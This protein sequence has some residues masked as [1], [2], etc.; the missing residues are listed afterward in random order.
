MAPALQFSPE[1]L[2]RAQGV[3]VAFFDVDGVL[4]DGGLYFSEA[5]ETLKRFNT[6]DGHGL[7]LLQKAGITPAVVTGRDSVPLRLRL[8]A[9]GVEHAVFGTEDKRPAAEQILA[10]LG[11][12]WTQAAAM[13]DDWPDL[14]VMRRSALACAP[15]NAQAEVLAQAH[16]ATRARGGDGAAREFCDLLLVA[17]GRYAAL[18]ADYCT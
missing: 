3:R 10:T 12:D 2:L 13:G 5:G 9:L 7:K 4:T 1:L 16:F 8:R 14:P 6:L 18:L 17:S 15:A 11:L